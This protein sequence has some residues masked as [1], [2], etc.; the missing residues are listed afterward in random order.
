MQLLF[1]SVNIS[2]PITFTRQVLLST[3][4]NIDNSHIR[5]IY[6]F[7]TDGKINHIHNIGHVS[8]D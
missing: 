1:Q 2:I 3:D 7:S 5:N 6:P 8:T 4:E